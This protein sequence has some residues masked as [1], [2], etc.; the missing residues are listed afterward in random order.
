MTGFAVPMDLLAAVRGPWRLTNSGRRWEAIDNTSA[1][2]PEQRA[3]ALSALE[4]CLAYM[5]ESRRRDGEDPDWGLP[6][7]FWEYHWFGM[8]LWLARAM[9]TLA[10]VTPERVRAWIEADV[11]PEPVFGRSWGT[12]PDEVVDNVARSWVFSIVNGLTDRL[13]RWFR[14]EAR[15]HLDPDERVRLIG[16]LKEAAPRLPWRL[17]NIAVRGILD[18]GG[19]GEKEY[20][21][22]LA[23]DP[24]AH[25]RT[26][27]EAASVC[28]RIERD[29]HPG[30][31]VGGSGR[32]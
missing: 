29:R 20:F 32:P 26:R 19:P 4:A 16:L 8:D 7:E 23:S 9:P 5:I 2:E 18:L 10:D 13:I 24:D 22:R 1:A 27:A 3:A 21:D 6:A 28:W 17:A 25:E 14:R 31:G 11:E 30:P 15:D 12:P